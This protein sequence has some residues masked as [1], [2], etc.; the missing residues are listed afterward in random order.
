MERK[1]SPTLVVVSVIALILVLQASS[2]SASSTGMTVSVQSFGNVTIAPGSHTTV[3]VAIA[4]P[5]SAEVTGDLSVSIAIGPTTSTTLTEVDVSV[6]AGA[7]RAV[8]VPV[9]FPQ[10]VPTGAIG[11]QACV[12]P[13]GKQSRCSAALGIQVVPPSPNAVGAVSPAVAI[14][15]A[16]G[17]G[18]IGAADA[19]RYALYAVNGDPRLPLEYQGNQEFEPD[20]LL[21]RLAST[22]PDDVAATLDASVPPM[23]AIRTTSA[24][25]ECF[26]D[27]A[28]WSAVPADGSGHVKVW[29]R[30]DR[31]GEAGTATDIA[32]L[33]N[34]ELWPRYAGLMGRQPLS[35]VD[36]WCNGGDGRLD[37]VLQPIAAPGELGFTAPRGSVFTCKAY[38]TYDVISDIG[39]EP[40]PIS[41]VE[42]L[43]TETVVA[44]ELF[45]SFQHAFDQ[46]GNG[47]INCDPYRWFDE[48]TAEWADITAFPQAVVDKIAPV[49]P[50]DYQSQMALDTF[51]RTA[52]DGEPQP[53]QYLAEAFIEYVTRV[54]PRA[55]GFVPAVYR[56]EATMTPLAA[57]DAFFADDLN[58][59][60]GFPSEFGEFAW[61]LG[62]TWPNDVFRRI[63]G[64]TCEA[65]GS[66]PPQPLIHAGAIT[67]GQQYP[68]QHLSS[69][70]TPVTLSPDI[71]AVRAD[72]TTPA[73]TRGF[74]DA[75][76]GEPGS[77][78]WGGTGTIAAS[79]QRAIICLLSG[80][81]RHLNVNRWNAQPAGPPVFVPMT[82]EA[83]DLPCGGWRGTVTGQAHVIEPNVGT[84]DVAWTATVDLPIMI[85]PSRQAATFTTYTGNTG[86][87]IGSGSVTYRS[88]NVHNDHP[89]VGCVDNSSEGPH[90][91]GITPFAD[92]V[93]VG[94]FPSDSTVPYMHYQALTGSVTG[95]VAT[96]PCFERAATGIGVPWW[97]SGVPADQELLNRTTMHGTTGWQGSLGGFSVTANWTWTLNSYPLPDPIPRVSASQLTVNKPVALTPTCGLTP[98]HAEGCGSPGLSR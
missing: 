47:L 62:N 37:I 74:A 20:D 29:Y 73:L 35:D 69:N 91:V 48:A 80:V 92:G 87:P 13:P 7:S 93:Q 23:S 4:N 63:N 2:C 12:T 9:I 85:D 66:S 42:W 53:H 33:V 6:A 56:R 67:L 38:P 77:E 18:Q 1:V 89:P 3:A 14:D 59:V 22:S 24:A 68:L 84:Y 10:D 86:N 28:H 57:A 17:S 40:L 31:T 96:N 25:P 60:G 65:L 97:Y 72:N 26:P 19:L 30:T 34:T 46:T 90:T 71:T 51:E 8:S 11:L 70:Y 49:A 15:S 36:S 61:V 98:G 88:Y 16:L 44:H 32:T 54:T 81:S 52:V 94:M 75:V 43:T 76:L 39:L 83:S 21:Q 64:T 78:R 95:P 58:L 27:Y 45:H 79:S 55:A 82:I 50:C 5:S 41:P